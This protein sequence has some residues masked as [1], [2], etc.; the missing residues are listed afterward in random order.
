MVSTTRAAASAGES[1]RDFSLIIAN[2]SG[3]FITSRTD[4]G[5]GFAGSVALFERKCGPRCRE[6]LRVER[7]VIFRRRR[8]GDKQARQAEECQFAQTG[9]A[10]T[11][12][13][14]ISR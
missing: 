4:A 2:F 3:F 7:L 12:D 6:N 9:R 11:G 13:D 14:K 5:E 8:V 10:G 1:R